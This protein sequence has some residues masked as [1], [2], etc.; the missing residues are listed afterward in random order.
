V[1][2]ALETYSTEGVY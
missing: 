1:V 2:T